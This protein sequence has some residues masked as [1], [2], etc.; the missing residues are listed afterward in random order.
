MTTP[1]TALAAQ[2]PEPVTAFSLTPVG[3]AGFDLTL[4]T[5]TLERGYEQGVFR[6]S[7]PIASAFKAA[8]AQGMADVPTPP[9]LAWD[10]LMRTGREALCSMAA[11]SYARGDNA[12]CQPE[13][14]A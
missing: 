5:W 14:G 9:L 2:Q 12:N 7:S 10:D 11:R 8:I 1:E 6:L 3:D 13:P 4:T